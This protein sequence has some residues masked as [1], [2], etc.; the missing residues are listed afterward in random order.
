MTRLFNFR[1]RAQALM[2]ALGL[3]LMLGSVHAA[4]GPDPVPEAVLTLQQHWAHANY[5]TEGKAR[6]QSFVAL[7]EEADQLVATMPDE[8][9]AH[10]WAGIVYSTYAGEVSMFK[11]G[12]QVKRARTELERA[13][14]L[15][16]EAMNGAAYT[17]L[18]ALLYQIPGFMG[19]DDEQAEELL[20]R[21]L[22][23]NADGIDANYF[24]A[25]Y[26][27]DQKRQDEALTYLEKALQAP[28]RPGRSVADAGRRAEVRNALQELN[29]QG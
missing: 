18:G 15:D 24:Y 16:P 13:L 28:D 27:I 12:K 1:Q 21:G 19:G 6:K 8:A 14:E 4:T 26:L 25:T 9:D 17:S 22:S 10:I 5:E 2:V 7:T 29:A 20:I 3:T 23:L 11:A